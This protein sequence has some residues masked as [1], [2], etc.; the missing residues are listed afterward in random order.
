MQRWTNVFRVLANVNRLKIIALLSVNKKMS[1]T[2]IA[3]QLPISFKATA[4]HLAILKNAAVASS[5]G[6]A[7]HVYYYLN[8]K[9]PTDFRKAIDLVL[10]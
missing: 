4:N 3:D 9:M 10:K 7:G 1:V 5:E 6:T 2:E 8:S